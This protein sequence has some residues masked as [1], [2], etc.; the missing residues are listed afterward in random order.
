MSN[1]ELQP[2]TTDAVKAGCTCLP[3]DGEMI[4]SET[5]PG[6]IT[7]DCPIHGSKP[8]EFVPPSNDENGEI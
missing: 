1:Q 5:W 8:G 2:G 7:R 3:A 4:E 6:W